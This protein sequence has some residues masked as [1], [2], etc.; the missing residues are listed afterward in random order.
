MLVVMKG[1]GLK[2]RLSSIS[3]MPSTM[4]AHDPLSVPYT[5]AFDCC[6]KASGIGAVI[7]SHRIGYREV[8]VF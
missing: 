5:Y 1:A 7:F 6:T 8:T 2:F 4:A 3:S